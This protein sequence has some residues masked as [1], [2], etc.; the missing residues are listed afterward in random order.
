MKALSVLTLLAL[1][2]LDGLA[3]AQATAPLPRSS[4]SVPKVSASVAPTASASAAPSASASAAPMNPRAGVPNPHVQAGDPHADVANPHARRVQDMSQMAPDLPAGTIEVTIADADDRPLAGIDVRLGILSQKISEG[5]QRSSKNALTDAEGR[6]RFDGLGTT[7]DKSYNVTVA[8][9][10]GEFGSSPFQLRDTGGHRV[11]L[12]VYPT[13]SD[14]SR[15]VVLGAFVSVEPR[16]DVFQLEMALHVFNVS[17]AAW[18]PS[19]VVIGLPDGFRA[20]AA[21]EAMS[22][23]R[24]EAIEGRGAALRG[25]FTPG[26]ARVA[27]RFQVPKPAESEF[28]ID[29]KLP[30]RVAQAQVVAAANP[31][32]TLEVA[33]FP[34]PET[35]QSPNGERVLITMKTIARGEDPIST[36]SMTLTGLRVPSS[37][38][39][40]AVVIAVVFAVLGGLAARGDIHVASAEKVQSDR[41]RARELILHEL[42]L[43]ERARSSGDIGPNAYERAHRTLLDALARIGVPEEKKATKKRKVA[44]SAS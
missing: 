1:V 19:D 12:H 42:V 39:W 9:G 13:T 35:R 5:E 38:R 29:L 37:G 30:S 44:R 7:I 27:F 17:K 40:V 16:D 25:T 11:L 43:V 32:M 10:G 15:T 33:G 34:E 18:I 31:E 21:G 8:S 20:F 36:M 23:A 41:A 2:L 24:F 22:D 28:T 26:E 14:M 4:V 3:A 6:V